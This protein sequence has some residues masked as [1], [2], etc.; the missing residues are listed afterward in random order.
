MKSLQEEMFENR[1]SL[2]RIVGISVET[3]PDRCTLDDCAHFMHC[4]IT[5]VQLGIQQLDNG[6]LKGINRRCTVEQVK[7]GTK[8]ILDCGL[9][10]DAHYMFD[11][12][13][14]GRVCR[15]S[16]N[17]DIEMIDKITNDPDFAIADQW[18]LYP[19]AT[20]PYTKILD[21]YNN[22]LEFTNNLKRKFNATIIQSFIRKRFK[23]R[24]CSKEQKID[25]T[26]KK[27][28]PYAEIDNGSYLLDVI[29]YAKQRVH[30]DTRL[31]RIIRDIPETSIVGG[32]K[33]TNLRQK[34]LEKID[35]DGLN[36]CKCI[37]CREIQGG[38]VNISELNLDIYEREKAGAS[39]LFISFEDSQGKLYGLAR[40][41]LLNV[42]SDC[43]DLLRNSAV[44]REVHV[45]GS[46]VR[47][48]KKDSDK[49]QHNGLGKRLIYECEK[50]AY[51]RGYKSIFI[52]SGE[53]V[54]NYYKDK[55]GYRIVKG[56]YNSVEYHYMHKNLEFCRIF[57]W[58]HGSYI[59][60]ILIMTT[61]IAILLKILYKYI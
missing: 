35:K 10:L 39:D 37:R 43:L 8:R 54:I 30:K 24:P 27:Y 53:G 3:R 13:G 22:M 5:T 21:W 51:K 50:I 16:P 36:P 28:L 14:P 7:E 44:I 4:G 19:T 45:Y 60:K 2:M 49:V 26:K 34:V 58:H 42:D 59:I 11:L 40:L 12:P 9:K 47:T 52:T 55:L 17:Q 20:T 48:T 46:I 61:I 41:R 33:T 1:S 31:N 15:L 29:V 25:I 32:N 18:K 23:F 38:E 56:I 6:I 57:G